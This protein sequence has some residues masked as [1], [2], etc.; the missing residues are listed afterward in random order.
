M[1]Y[2]TEAILR[3]LLRFTAFSVAL[4]HLLAAPG[5]TRSHRPAQSSEVLACGTSVE[6]ERDALA[7][8]RYLESRIQRGLQGP[9]AREARRSAVHASAPTDFGDV[10][11]VEDD[12]TIISTFNFFNLRNR[13]VR[14]EPAGS[15]SYRVSPSTTLFNASGGS[16]LALADDDYRSIDLQFSFVFYG[17]SYQSVFLNSDGNLTFLESDTETSERDLSRFSSGPPRIGPFFNDLD[18]SATLSS[19]P[20]AVSF[21]RDPDGIAFI[22]SGVPEWGLTNRNS[23]SAK[24]FQNGSIEF[25][26]GERVDATDAIVG[27]SPGSG[28]GGITAVVY[29]TGLPTGELSGTI[30]EVFSSSSRISETALA[31]KFYQTHP[32]EFDQLVVFLAFPF[33][34]DGAFAYQLNVANQIDGIGLLREDNSRDY[35]SN[36]RLESFVMMGALDGPGRYPEDPRLKFMRTYNSLEILAH[37]VGHRWAAYPRVRDSFLFSNVLLKR[38]RAHWSFFF[39]ADASVMEGNEIL[40]RGEPSGSQRFATA[41]VTNR[42]SLLDRYLMGL[43]A[44]GSITPMFRVDNVTGTFRNADSLPSFATTVFGGTRRDFTIEDIVAANGARNPSVFQ[45]PKVVRQAFILLA[46]KGQPPSAGQISKLQ[47]LR[48]AWVPYFNQITHGK[49]FAVTT[50]QSSPGTTPSIIY[51]PYLVGNASRYTGFALANWGSAPADVLLRTWNNDGTSASLP[52]GIINPRMITLA[53]GAQ[54]ALLGSQIHGLSLEDTRNGWIEARSSSSQVTGFFLAGDIDQNFLDGASVAG[55]A[56]RELYFTHAGTASGRV[57]GRTYR[58]VISAVNPGTTPAQLT[59]RLV[60]E[61]GLPLAETGRSLNAKGRLS[62]D[63]AALFP[64]VSLPAA[65]YVQLSSTAGVIGYQSLET[66]ATIFAL[67]AQPPSQA[68]KLYSAQF[69]SGAAGTA[70]YFTDVNIINTSSSARTVQLQL[71][72]DGGQQVGN[73]VSLSPLGPGAQLRLRGEDLFGLPNP[74][75]AATIQTGSL[76]ISAN[77]P[78]IIGDVTF[79]EPLDER[80]L[81]ALPLNGSPAADLVLS[82][83]AEGSGGGDK[84]YFTG[85]ALYNPGATTVQARVEVYSETGA[86]TGTATL[87]LPPGN[88]ISRTLPQLVPAI[89]SQVR[90]YIRISTTGGPIIA[91]EL[92]GD[93]AL[94]FLAAVPP[95]PIQP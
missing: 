65:G 60:N 29:S 73:S 5:A 55:E 33:D 52:A 82:Q 61:N 68:L 44:S 9:G 57:P 67:P 26:Y 46:R 18:P 27:I 13:S 50:L 4:V 77:G 72:N 83:V 6:R 38:D 30:V 84:P 59:F 62:D 23:F 37:E 8:G 35:G 36:G 78:G 42:Y 74:A 81:A 45:S 10:A 75:T 90:G 63:I 48:D 12:G 47:S 2:S 43:E 16:L 31:K 32:D 40:D 91:F 71:V 24:L 11:V 17:T 3:R 15:A 34:L 39:N 25:A 87:A 20:P 93:Q 19:P 64:G 51:F 89:S 21:R 92:F 94:S 95:Q 41:E 76:V 1:R 88:R 86:Q 70:R 56:L 53:Q 7:R 69:A 66:A 54:T 79:G 49:A 85:I 80:F 58:N 14:F 22:W 28:S